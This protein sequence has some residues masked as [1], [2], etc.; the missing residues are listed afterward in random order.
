ME[1]RRRS[2]RHPCHALCAVRDCWHV[3]LS[4]ETVKAGDNRCRCDWQSRAASVAVKAMW[5]ATWVVKGMHTSMWHPCRALCAVW[6]V[7][8]CALEL[9]LLR[10]EGTG[11]GMTGSPGQHRRLLPGLRGEAQV[12]KAVLSAASD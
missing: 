10:L 9:K 6:A 7:L 8:A 11:A 1:E 5:E 12:S 2:V 3:L 4:R